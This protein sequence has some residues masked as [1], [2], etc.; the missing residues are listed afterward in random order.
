[1]HLRPIQV[2]ALQAIHDYGGLL[3]PIRVGGGKTILSYIAGALLKEERVL[4]LIPAKLKE[5]TKREF[6]RLKRHWRGPARMHMISYELLS[7]DRG[8]Q[9]LE[10]YRPGLIVADEAQKV[11]STSAACTKRLRR[12]LVES[13][14]DCR[15]ID[16]SGTITKRSIL[17]YYHRQNWAVPDGLQALPR[18]WNEVKDWADAIDEKVSPTGRLM[19]GA[20]LQMCNSE[21][22]QELAQDQRKSTSTRIIR[23]AYGRRLLTAPGV[24]GTEEQFDGAMALIIQGHEFEPS[25]KVVE[26]F[27]G[28]REKWELPDGQ[29]IDMPAT[30]WRH[31]RELVQ[32]FY[33]EWDPPPPVDWLI[34]RKIWAKTIREILKCYRDIDSPLGAVRAVE[35]GRIPWAV[36]PLLEWRAIKPTFKPVTVAKWI[37]D[38]CLQWCA[39][40]AT[41][42][43]GIIW[44]NEVAF[45]ERL[46]KE[47]G[48]PYYGAKGLCKG[49]AIEDEV[50]TCIASIAANSEG[51]NLQQFSTSLT[52]STPPGGAI[53]EQKL[54]RTHR[55][56]QDADVVTDDVLLC[57]YEQ[58]DVFRRARR[59]AE[60]IERTTN[61]CQKLNFADVTTIEEEEVAKRNESEPLWSKANVEFFEADTWTESE[62]RTSAMDP[63]QR[64]EMRRRGI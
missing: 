18:K 45:G 20:L 32:G 46:S 40:W 63:R 47:T 24:C 58:W 4:L 35:E 16:M 33:Y 27:R 43:R 55:D 62:L 26:A 6:A 22:L 3:G 36:E 11:K 34:A 59:D 31:A 48:I 25:E 52:V 10:A 50:K 42:N 8:V 39:K 9:E 51:R 61:Q 1:M 38:R 17:E 7:R 37:D 28:L 44:I 53:W 29:P 2:A 14:K 57:C 60:Y 64:A 5:K 13:N 30:L 56:G 12:Y 41:K 15:Y 23:Q 19:P 54:G 21:E 49:K